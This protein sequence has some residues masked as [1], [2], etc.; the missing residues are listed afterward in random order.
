MA[1]NALILGG[2]EMI[3]RIVGVMEI[4]VISIKHTTHPLVTQLAM[5]HRLAER[6]DE[7][8]RRRREQNQR[9]FEKQP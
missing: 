4:H 7:V 9:D 3:P 2:D 1:I 6:H 8:R 5:Q